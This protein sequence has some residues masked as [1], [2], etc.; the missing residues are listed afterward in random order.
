MGNGHITIEF[1]EVDGKKVYIVVF[2]NE[3][4]KTL[5]Q[6]SLSAQYSKKRRVEEK[7]YKQQL[8]IALVTKN[9]ETKKLKVDYCIVNFQRKDDQAQFEQDFEKGLEDIKPAATTATTTTA[10]SKTETTSPA[11]TEK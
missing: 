2:R 6:G 1:A 9:P 4:G 10:A 5:Y 8:K 3:I 7:A 11:K